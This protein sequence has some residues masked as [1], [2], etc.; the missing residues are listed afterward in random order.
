MSQRGQ[1]VLIISTSETGLWVCFQPHCRHTC[2][3][4]LTGI[5]IKAPAWFSMNGLF[6]TNTTICVAL[7][8]GQR[9]VNHVQMCQRRIVMAGALRERP[10]FPTFRAVSSL[11]RAA[12]S[13]RLKLTDFTTDK[14]SLMSGIVVDIPSSRRAQDPLNT[15]SGKHAL[16]LE[17]PGAT[18][19]DV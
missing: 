5:G 19:A 6:A 1:Q 7:C 4:G 14:G 9:D 8:G 18:A 12:C 13:V 3:K 16:A 17:A 2:V 10:V 11:C 15:S